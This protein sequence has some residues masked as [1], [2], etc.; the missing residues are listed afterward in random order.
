MP[1]KKGKGKGKG[2]KGDS[3]PIKANVQTLFDD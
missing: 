2:K 1:V 3:I